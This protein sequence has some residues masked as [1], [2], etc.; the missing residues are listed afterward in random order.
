MRPSG[1]FRRLARAHRWVGL[2]SG[3][4][5]LWL[6]VTG[7][8]MQHAEDLELERA[9]V[10]AAWLLERYA[11][12]AP[13]VAAAFQVGDRWASQAGNHLY[14]DDRPVAAA[15][16]P[17]IG[18]LRLPETIVLATRERV[19]L[20]DA[21]GALLD[22]VRREHGLPEAPSALGASRDGRLVLRT[23]DGEFVAD[24]VE[25][26]WQRR[27]PGAVTWSRP[28]E[29]PEALRASVQQDA[30]TRV[31]TQERVLRDLHAGRFFGPW[32]KWLTDLVAIAFLVL[33][34]TGFWIWWRAKKEFGRK[35]AP[36]KSR[37]YP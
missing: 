4:F 3:A 24:V 6:A 20:L 12:D 26:R 8:V 11:I 35:Q 10:R 29:L 36:T 17:L 25:L 37:V 19:V 2:A 27:A 18:A 1:L 15:G 5:V 7:F 32:G 13:P 28:G 23:R 14:L 33:T 16:E 31:L 9:P 34:F 22:V 30:R 21:R